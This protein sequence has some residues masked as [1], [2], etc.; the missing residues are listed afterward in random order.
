LAFTHPPHINGDASGS[1][2]QVVWVDELLA[3][4]LFEVGEVFVVSQLRGWC[5]RSFDA[6]KGVDSRE[7]PR[8]FVLSDA[9]GDSR[10]WRGVV[11]WTKVDWGGS[12]RSREK[13][14]GRGGMGE[15]RERGD[16]ISRTRVILLCSHKVRASSNPRTQSSPW[17]PIRM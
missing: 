3:F 16:F 4:E 15:A 17:M 2:C 7:G 9:V 11:G 1:F 14:D 6:D 8:L 13:R 10:G 5:G 12:V